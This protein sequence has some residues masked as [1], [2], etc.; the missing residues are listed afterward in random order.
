MI[1]VLHTAE[2]DNVTGEVVDTTQEKEEKTKPEETEKLS[3]EED[4]G[5]GKRKN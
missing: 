1:R 3:N 4:R 2:G 5:D